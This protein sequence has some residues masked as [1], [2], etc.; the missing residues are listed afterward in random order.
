[1]TFLLLYVIVMFLNHTRNQLLVSQNLLDAELE[2]MGLYRLL[3]CL[4]VTA[5]L[6]LVVI[7]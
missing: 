4:S 5:V 6:V 2:L 1:M 7:I 3:V